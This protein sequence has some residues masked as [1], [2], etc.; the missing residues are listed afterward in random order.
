MTAVSFSRMSPRL[1][2]ALAIFAAFLVAFG[3]RRIILQAHDPTALVLHAPQKPHAFPLRVEPGKRHLVDANGQPFLLHGDTAWSL[4]ADLT[5]EEIDIYLADRR[6]RGFNTILVNLIEHQFARKAPANIAGDAPFLEP[7]NFAKPNEAY[8]AHADWVLS[9]AR[10]YGMLV[11]LTPAYIGTRGG[12]EGWWQEMT[13]NSEQTLRAYGRFLGARYRSFDNIVWVNGGDYDPPDKARVRA[14]ALGLK[15]AAPG[16]L[17]TAH[18][19]PE[20]PVADFWEGESW[21]DL[22]N[23]YTYEPVCPKVL[24]AYAHAGKRPFFLIESAYENEHGAGARRIRTQAYQ[25][26]LCGAS[27]Q[28]YGNNPIWHFRHSGLHSAPGDWW[29]HLGSRGAQSMTHLLNLFTE[30]DWWRLEPDAS[31]LTVGQGKGEDLAAAARMA[32]GGAALIYLPSPRPITVNLGRL[33][34]P[35]IEASWFDPSTGQRLAIK[36]VPSGAGGAQNF[37]PPGMN[38]AGDGDWLLILA[39]RPLDGAT[40]PK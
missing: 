14:I 23:V 9:R 8:F 26:L 28:V 18:I 33:S 30:L 40:H 17:H 38:A 25:A 36:D 11:L 1:V 5:R 31:L 16:Q 34:S 21:L 6:A 35:R 2:L 29:H 19:A 22:A 20:T 32:D 37:T 4:I 10:D 27:G 12:A 3:A 15:E 24:A 7:G 13:G 39:S